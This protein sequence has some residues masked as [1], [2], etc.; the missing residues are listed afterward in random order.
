[1]IFVATTLRSE[2]ESGLSPLDT[3]HSLGTNAPKV[4]E[5]G[6]YGD[7]KFF[8]VWA[9][10]SQAGGHQPGFEPIG[11]G[12]YALPATH[13]DSQQS[14]QPGN[15]MSAHSKGNGENQNPPSE[16]RNGRL[17]VRGNKARY[18]ESNLWK[19]VS[20]E[21][22]QGALESSSDEEED[23]VTDSN[24]LTAEMANE[25]SGLILGVTEINERRIK[26]PDTA[27]ILQLW[28]IF[29]DNVNPI[30]KIIHA[31]TLQQ[32]IISAIGNMNNI[33][34]PL[35]AILCSIYTLAVTSLPPEECQKR[36]GES[37]DKLCARYRSFARQALINAY[38]LR[39]SDITVLIAFVYLIISSAQD[40]DFE[41]R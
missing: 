40:G 12:A 26:H 5:P 18:T 27:T 13:D 22:E 32:D 37:R 2:P 17:V 28:Q 41:S 8:G 36:F 7:T 3:N 35:E 33:P 29:L 1:M 39:T 14:G 38:F 30:T 24:S 20:A 25:S 31:P 34:K 19:V 6:I 23:E 15:T 10:P 16:G 21:A 4:P 11:R 9:T